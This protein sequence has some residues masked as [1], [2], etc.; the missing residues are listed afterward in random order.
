MIYII[1]LILSFFLVG[2]YF[3][4][5]SQGMLKTKLPTEEDKQMGMLLFFIFWL[6][7]YMSFVSCLSAFSH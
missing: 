1:A 3:F 6:I 2:G 7:F 4:I 5:V